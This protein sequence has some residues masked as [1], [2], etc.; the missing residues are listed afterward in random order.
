MSDPSS[1]PCTAF[2]GPR[3]LARG[4]LVDVALAVKAAL[5]K[6][7]TASLLTFEDASG[8]V[9]DLDLRGTDTEVVPRL[10]PPERLVG[11]PVGDEHAPARGRGRPK[12]GVVA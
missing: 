4:A 5:T 10:A 3:L 9:I 7:P 6:S 8:R 11:Q 12:L 2:D 1:T